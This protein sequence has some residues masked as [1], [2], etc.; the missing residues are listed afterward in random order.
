MTLPPEEVYGPVDPKAIMEVAAKKLP[1]GAEKPGSVVSVRDTQGQTLRAV[2]K[3]ARGE[4]ALLDFNHPLAG[5]VLH[6]EVEIV[7]V[8]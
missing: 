2:V 5:K 1:A 8:L 3:E 4:T 7:G 6:F